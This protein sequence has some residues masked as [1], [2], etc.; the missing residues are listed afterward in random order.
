MCKELITIIVC[1]ILLVVITAA[2]IALFAID[3]KRAKLGKK[4]Y[5]WVR[6][7]PKRKQK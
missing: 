2:V 4:A 7:E 5:L 6:K 3:Y 1:S